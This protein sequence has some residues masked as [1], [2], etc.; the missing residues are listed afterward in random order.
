M[1]RSLW[2]GVAGLKTHQMQMDVIGNNVA[3]VNTTSYKAQKT[4]FGDLLYQRFT[5]MNHYE[6]VL[7]LSTHN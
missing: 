2:S 3:N 4:T 7:N 6:T 1:M 5:S